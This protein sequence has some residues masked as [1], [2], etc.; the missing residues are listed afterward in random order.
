MIR[1]RHILF[2]CTI[3]PRLWAGDAAD[4]LRI[5]PD[6]EARVLLYHSFAKGPDTPEVNTVQARVAQPTGATGGT[7]LAGP[8][9]SFTERAEKPTALVLASPEFRPSRP[10]TVSFWWRLDSPMQPETSFHVL[11]LRG[12]GI[13]S[14]FVRGKGEW[15]GLK[16]PTYVQQIYY[17][18][19]MKNQNQLG[20]RVW[21]EPNEWH[22][23]AFVFR[24]ANRVQVYW[25]GA[26][27]TDYAIRGRPFA[28]DEGG[29]LE[30]GPTWLFH[31][32]TIDEILVLDRALDANEIRAYM[33][34]VQRLCELAHAV[35]D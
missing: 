30:I 15:C 8:G 13:V 6:L 16:Q 24:N 23:T 2:L 33:T 26:L 12:G 21:L 20:S 35:Q 7:G 27:R 14:N 32:M 22:H 3:L 11:T 29:T 5:P 19:G 1:P 18:S 31:P 25:D 4:C 34:S 28:P 9:L 10:L 17:F